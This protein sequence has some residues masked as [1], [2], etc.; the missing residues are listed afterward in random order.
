M[1]DT[2]DHAAAPTPVAGF[3]T[4]DN[5]DAEPMTPEQRAVLRKLADDKGEP[6]DGNLTQSQAADRI[7]A[8]KDM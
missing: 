5:T 7:E 2:P 1:P 6:F 3:A 4:A 8:L